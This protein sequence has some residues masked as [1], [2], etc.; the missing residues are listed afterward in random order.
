MRSVFTRCG[1]EGTAPA[2]RTRRTL[3]AHALVC[4]HS[5]VN[6]TY[7]ARAVLNR[8]VSF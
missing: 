3:G 5:A 7:R 4:V 2:A 8:D 6:R 1:A